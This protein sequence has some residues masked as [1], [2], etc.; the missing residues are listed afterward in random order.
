MQTS[1]RCARTA[2]VLLALVG[3]TQDREA[4]K[5][6]DPSEWSVTT[7]DGV[8]LHGE[9]FGAGPDLLFVHG[10]PSFP[11]LERPAW[12]VELAAHRRVHLFHQRGS[13]HSSRP[14]DLLPATE[15]EA[16]AALLETYGLEPHLRDIGRVLD[17]RIGQG[18]GAVLVGHSF[19]AYLAALLAAEQPERVTHLVLLAPADVL[20][21]VLLGQSVFDRI[22]QALPEQERSTYRARLLDF[23][24]PATLAG[25]T[26]AELARGTDWFG[27]YF[28]NAIGRTIPR[29]DTYP[30][31]R[32]A[33]GCAVAGAFLGIDERGDASEDLAQVRARTL[34]VH[35]ANDLTPTAASQAFAAA[36]PDA[37]FLVMP[38]TSHFF[39]G[40]AKDTAEEIQ[41]FLAE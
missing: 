12:L 1:L 14:L 31:M 3:A 22:E 11:P 5:L 18:E 30:Q 40:A 39:R 32:W 26:D 29:P 24:V 21:G 28:L 35:A 38:D 9:S 20:E 33:G 34:V 10:G 27:W 19:G 23:L 7:E 6:T 17:E 25:A 41:A 37:R 8:T 4:P 2:L 13:G 15:D 16:R 36:I